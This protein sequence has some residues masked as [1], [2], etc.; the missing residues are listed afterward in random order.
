MVPTTI[1]DTPD[2]SIERA[3]AL[4]IDASKIVTTRIRNA[5]ESV[6]FKT[7]ALKR[8]GIASNVQIRIGNTIH[9]NGTDQNLSF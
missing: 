2:G 1:D 3:A 6:V 4:V 5:I 7:V 8:H 9:A